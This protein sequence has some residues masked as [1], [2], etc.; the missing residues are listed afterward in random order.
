MLPLSPRATAG[1]RC[2]GGRH[3]PGGSSASVGTDAERI[4]MDAAVQAEIDFRAP[5]PFRGRGVP[6]GRS[7]TGRAPRFL[8]LSNRARGLLPLKPHPRSP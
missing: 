8:P 7:A 5:R 4:A 6:A 1:P 3:R 2:S